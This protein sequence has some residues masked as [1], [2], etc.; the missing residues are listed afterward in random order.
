[1]GS[2]STGTACQNINRNF[3][4]IEINRETFEIEKE[5]INRNSK[6]RNMNYG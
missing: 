2:G 5:R 6:E 1:M 3:I 4:G